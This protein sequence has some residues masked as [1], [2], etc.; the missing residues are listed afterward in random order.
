[1]IPISTHSNHGQEGAIVQGDDC[2]CALVAFG[3]VG[4]G[5][6]AEQST[7]GVGC[8]CDDSQG[9]QTKHAVMEEV[10]CDQTD[11]NSHGKLDDG[12]GEAGLHGLGC[13]LQIQLCAHADEEQTDQC[14]GTVYDT[15][16]EAA[17]LQRCRAQ[18]V[19]ET[20][21][22]QGDDDD[23]ARNLVQPLFNGN[24]HR[25]SSSFTFT[26]QVISS[27]SLTKKCVSNRSGNAHPVRFVRPPFLLYFLNFSG[28]P[29]AFH[30]STIQPTSRFVKF[31]FLKIESIFL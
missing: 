29:S 8:C 17:D 1:M 16:G 27:R 12:D 26:F 9:T 24:L 14:A 20:A 19:H 11:T 2:D 6:G 10:C 25:F 13:A 22:E 30:A 3:A 28:L 15:G 31:V 7:V 21:Q 4:L 5:Q 23:A 18:S